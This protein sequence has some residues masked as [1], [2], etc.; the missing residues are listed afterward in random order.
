MVIRIFETDP[1]AMPRPAFVDDTVGRFHSGRMVDGTP[2]QLAEWRVTTGDPDVAEAVAKL[3]GGSPVE[4]DSTA[5]NYIEVQTSHDRIA[6]LLS[7]PDAITADMKLWNRNQLIHHCDGVE[8]LSPDEDRGKACGCPALMEDRKAAAKS[9][10]GPSPSI[11]VTF[12]LA[13]APDLGLFRFQSGSWTLAAV[14][15]EYDNALTKVDGQAVAE[16]ALEL[17]EYTTKKGRDV[18]YRK[19]VI[20]GIKPVPVTDAH[21]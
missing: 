21:S 7:G 6:V 14:L 8:Y 20:R 11:S 4:T 2:E 16:L 9:Y 12:R 5:E 3:F 13:G 10:R 19:P 15:H 18:S 1:D 17:V